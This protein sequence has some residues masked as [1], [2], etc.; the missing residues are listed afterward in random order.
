MRLAT[1]NDPIQ[2]SGLGSG[3]NFSI[4]ASAKAF[5][6]LSSN[7]YQNKILAVIREVSC[8]AADAHTA[9]GKDFSSIQIHLPTYGEPWF[10]VRDFGAGL[11]HNDVMLLY[12]T[13]FQSTKDQSDD[14][15]GGFGLGSKSPFSVADQFTV[16][17]WHGGM[18]SE[19]IMYK[20]AGL[21]RVNV[22]R[23]THSNEPSGLLVQVA[24]DKNFQK[25]VEEANTFFAPWATKPAINIALTTTSAWWE[26]A[27]LKSASDINGYPE[28]ALDANRSMEFTAFM[29]LVPYKITL[30]AIPN[31]PKEFLDYNFRGSLFLAFRVGEISINPSRETLS[32]DTQTCAAIIQRLNAIKATAKTQLETT[33]NN[34]SSLYEANTVYANTEGL[35]RNFSNGIKPTWNGK[36]VSRSVD[37]ELSGVGRNDF[38]ADVSMLRYYRKSW[39]QRKWA[40]ANKNTIDYR[41]YFN[42][43]KYPFVWVPTITNK[44]YKQLQHL[45]NSTVQNPP[46]NFMLVSGS[47]YAD[48]AKVFEDKGMP[49]ILDG[50]TL[51]DPPKAVP[52]PGATKRTTYKGYTFDTNLRSE[53]TEK[54]I[55]LNGGGLVVTMFDGNPVENIAFLREAMQNNWFTTPPTTIVG[56]RKARLETKSFSALLTSKGWEI[57]GKD[58]AERNLNTAALKMHAK[59]QGL[60]HIFELDKTT[61]T[62]TKLRGLARLLASLPANTTPWKNAA[63][64]FASFQALAAHLQYGGGPFSFSYTRPYFSAVHETAITTSI[65]EGEQ[66]AARIKAFFAAN[67]MLLHVNWEY[68]TLDYQTFIDYINR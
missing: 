61:Y 3:N 39:G 65:A 28:W 13:Y 16:T 48:V 42:E 30:S 53:P 33:I 22:I 29:G 32:Y 36:P 47:T 38:Q 19:Y 54:D 68:G 9:A 5:E 35:L 11:S 44:V 63:P 55:D 49:P 60:Y 7:L 52:V 24:V 66:L 62:A 25:W 67:P 31:C 41:H 43:D 12:T 8:N 59:Q 40:G 15:I 6:I 46:T 4:A 21:P 23:Q 18:K 27:T 10:S 14:L 26:T 45:H 58:W 20:D 1:I 57:Y 17:S 37:L 56:F 34:C 64:W 51:P 2:S 50:T